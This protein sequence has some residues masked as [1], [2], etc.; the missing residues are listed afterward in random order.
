M[1]QVL[2]AAALYFGVV[3]GTG[4]VL[5]PPRILWLVPRLGTMVAELIELPVMALVMVL[6]AHR[7]VSRLPVPATTPRRLGIGLFALC[8]LLLAEFTLVLWLRGLTIAEYLAGRDPVAGM[9]YAAM[10]ALFAALPG[11]VARK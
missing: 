10:L 4:L 6:A 7:V 11:L 1:M 9:V 5:G 8:F 3:F 2:K